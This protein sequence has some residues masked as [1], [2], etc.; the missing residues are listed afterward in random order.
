MIRRE[1]RSPDAPGA[2]WIL[3]SQ[4]D[5]ARLSARLAEH[6]GAGGVSELVAR[7]ELLWAIR[8]HDDGWREWE[9]APDIEPRLGRPRS[10]TEMEVP[11]SLEIWSRSI[12]GAAEFGPLAGYVVAGHF[13]AL[14]R[15]YDA[16]WRNNERYRPAAERFL[17]AH[18]NLMDSCLHAWQ[19]RRPSEHTPDRARLALAQLQMFDLLSLWFCCSEATEPEELE[20]P[21]GATIRLVPQPSRSDG[22]D[23]VG[24]SPWPFTVDR[25]EDLVILGRAVPVRHYKTAAEM[26]TGKPQIVRLRWHLEPLAG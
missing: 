5:H 14:A 21:G 9:Q 2:Q 13:C 12:K 15:R 10:F 1:C 4:V 11:D 6:W 17:A 16:N 8:H 25:M 3:I 23:H 19:S 7:K 20:T 26:P 24:F 18:E 22:A